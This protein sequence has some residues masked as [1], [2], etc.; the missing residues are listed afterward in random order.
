[1]FIT[2]AV[3]GSTLPWRRRPPLAARLDPYLRGLR[4]LRSRLLHRDEVPL[5]PFPAVER[6]LRPLL[7]ESARTAARWLSG[8]GTA[9]VARRLR[10]AGAR[11]GK[12]V[13]RLVATSVTVG[14]HQRCS[15]AL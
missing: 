5:T 13:L 3:I 2:Y 4:P 10:E 1:M 7:A 9:A 14:I 15:R 8:S 12:I 11:G 6:L